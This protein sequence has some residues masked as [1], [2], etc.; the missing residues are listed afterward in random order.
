[1]KEKL[2]YMTALAMLAS[3]CSN[4]DNPFLPG[5]E[6]N[7]TGEVKM[8]TETITATNGDANGT[9]RADVDANASFTWSKDDQIAVHVSDGKYYTTEALSEDEGGNKSAD[10]TVSY[11]EGEER[12]A[13]AVYPASI[14][15]ESTANYGQ[16]GA[17]LD[18]TLPS[19]YTLAQVSGTTTPCPMIADNT[20]ETLEFRQLCG[21]LRLTVKSIPAKATGMVIQFPGKKVNG[22]F[23]IES[24]VTPGTSTILT[25]APA[26]GEDRITVTFATGT[27]EATINIPLPTGEYE[28][29]YITPLGCATKVVALRHIKAGGYTAARA[30]ARKLTTTMVSFSV[31]ESKKVIFSLGNLQA[32]TSD[33][34][35]NWTWKF[36]P[37]QYTA[38]KNS[39]ANTTITGT[40]TV[41]AN[42]TVDLFGYSTDNANNYYGIIKS[43][44]E[45]YYADSPTRGA[46][47]DWAENN[48]AD[49]D[50]NFWYT[51]EKSE[52]EYLIN[53]RTAPKFAKVSVC[54][55][56]GLLLFPDNFSWNATTMGD[57]PSTV[58]DKNGNYNSTNCSISLSNWNNLEAA[59]V[60]F[61]PGT[62][63]RSQN[64]NT[65]SNLSPARGYY[66][67][68]DT[69]GTESGSGTTYDN[70]STYYL[71]FG[72][73][74]LFSTTYTMSK[75]SGAAIRLVHEIPENEVV[76]ENKQQYVSEEW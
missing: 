35:S 69:N 47:K 64:T 40:G 15:T 59:G 58:D 61:L 51:M 1:M 65:V 68:S 7:G 21:L 41:S 4:E 38:I 11:P 56:Y 26:D 18:V 45:N 57:I 75:R 17:A 52:W 14:V 19:S 70:N 34:G 44:R 23:S 3:A 16:S 27:T 74:N 73:G 8:I 55:V 42:G 63:Y 71:Y 32:T 22:N 76:I 43:K 37:T 39:T 48:I 30:H 25:G 12:D 6:N 53:T 13:F 29:V 46:F 67:F 2:I 36:A 33:L 54:G 31:G 9:T 24:P 28:D 72:Q 5:D 62:G 60:V 50:A 20:K 49:Y 10:F 66:W